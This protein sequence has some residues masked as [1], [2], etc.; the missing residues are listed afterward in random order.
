MLAAKVAMARAAKR[1]HTKW[2]QKRGRPVS[3][4]KEHYKEERN[5]TIYGGPRK[6]RKLKR[7]WRAAGNVRDAKKHSITMQEREA[8]AGPRKAWRAQMREARGIRNARV[9]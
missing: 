5:R 6:H 9:R 2:E 1:D 7:R 3:H 4:D 8:L